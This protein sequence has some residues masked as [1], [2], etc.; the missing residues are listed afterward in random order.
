[1]AR[2]PNE[3]GHYE[4][5]LFD[6]FGIKYRIVPQTDWHG[7]RTQ[8]NIFCGVHDTIRYVYLQKIFNGKN[9]TRPCRQC[10]LD[11]LKLNVKKKDNTTRNATKGNLG[12]TED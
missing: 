3:I 5:K 4:T 9:S 12:I 7:V 2:R 8:V 6:K 1:M 10:Y 11:E